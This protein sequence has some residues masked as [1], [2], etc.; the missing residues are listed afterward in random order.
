MQPA[1]EH[2]RAAWS[3]FMAARERVLHTDPITGKQQWMQD[4]QHREAPSVGARARAILH[5]TM[6]SDSFMALAEAA[7]R[8]YLGE[9]QNADRRGFWRPRK[10]NAPQVFQ[11]V[12][13]FG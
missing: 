4:W 3:A 2:E 1:I 5:T 10:S 11:G 7:L 8:L 6:H 12:R 9:S 13:H